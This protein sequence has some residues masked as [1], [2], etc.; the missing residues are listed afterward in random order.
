[1]L[2]QNPGFDPQ[3]CI[4]LSWCYIIDF[5]ATVITNVYLVYMK[6]IKF[7]IIHNFYMVNFIMVNKCQNFHFVEFTSG[8][9][10]IENYCF[11]NF[12][13]YFLVCMSI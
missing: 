8:I 10:R 6:N 1:M 11:Y 3:N 7:Q 9:Q 12:S 13:Y 2:I 4:N 5:V